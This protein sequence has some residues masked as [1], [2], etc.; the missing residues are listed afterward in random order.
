MPSSK[1]F[2]LFVVAIG[3]SFIGGVIITYFG[4]LWAGGC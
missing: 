2:S 4:I 3:V 1:L